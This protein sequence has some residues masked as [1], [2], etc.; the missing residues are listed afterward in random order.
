MNPEAASLKLEY[1]DIPCLLTQN[2]QEQPVYQICGVLPMITNIKPL[3]VSNGQRLK[4]LLKYRKPL[5]QHI[6][7]LQVSPFV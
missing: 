5:Q 6:H 2:K 3:S 4:P 7:L 1:S